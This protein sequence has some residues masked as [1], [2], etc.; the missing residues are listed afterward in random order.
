MA[1]HLIDS[2]TFR[3]DFSEDKENGIISLCKP[4]LYSSNY[5]KA[6]YKFGYKFN[7]DV[8]RNIRTKFVNQLKQ[9]T[10][11]SFS[12][13]DNYKFL[14]KPL[15]MLNQEVGYSKFS[16]LIYPA[17]QR[18]PL[19]AEIVKYVGRFIP[20]NRYF[21]EYELIKNDTKSVK[22]DYDKYYKDNKEKYLN[23][24]A[25]ENAKKAIE[26]LMI[27]ISNGD[28]FRIGQQK[29]KYRPYF[30]DYLIFNDEKMY[31]FCKIQDSKIL[32]ID[33]INTTGATID[34]MLRYINS[35]NDTN[36]I[37]IFTIIGKELN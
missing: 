6:V 31:D 25:W 26:D 23:E 36:E 2:E 27:K 16:T 11:R 29:T 7:D 19:V 4:E 10:N 17:S 15:I 28:Y 35:I 34:E 12:E 13:E 3:F 1:I 37:F 32:L 22:F 20:R 24:N 14:N 18:S 9:M 5:D 21:F 33:D 8:S 30:Y